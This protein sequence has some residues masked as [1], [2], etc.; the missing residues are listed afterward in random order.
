MP[1][2]ADRVRAWLDHAE[3]GPVLHHSTPGVRTTPCHEPGFQATATT[4]GAALIMGLSV[5]RR[6]VRKGI[7]TGRIP[8]RNP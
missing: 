2:D 8:V 5:R 7:E 6:I 3:R 1:L 4:I